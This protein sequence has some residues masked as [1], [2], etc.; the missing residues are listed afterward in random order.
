MPWRETILPHSP[1][2]FENVIQEGVGFEAWV[3]HMEIEKLAKEKLIKL[4]VELTLKTLA[5]Y[6]DADLIKT[7]KELA[8][9]IK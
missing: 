8:K 9:E 6:S 7:V 1:A 4:A 5:L 2:D 3:Q